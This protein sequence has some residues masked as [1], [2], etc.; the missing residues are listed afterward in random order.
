MTTAYTSILKLALPVQGELVGTWGDVVNNNITSMIEEAIAGKA[1]ISTWVVGVHTLTTANGTTS[2]SRCAILE[3]SGSPGITSY[4]ICPAATKLYI[5]KNSV[6]GGYTVTLKTA[7]GS[8][9]TVP[10]G[11][12]ML[13]YCDGTNVVAGVDYVSA[14]Y[15]AYTSTNLSGGG[16]GQVPYQS[17]SGTT[18]M[19]AAGSAGQVLTSNGT[20]APSWSNTAISATTATNLAGGGAGQVPYQSGAGA[21]SMLAAG[22]SGQVLT[23]NGASAPS[24]ASI[25]AQTYPGAGIAVSTGSAWTTSKTS[26]SGTIVGTTDTQTLTNKTMT[27]VK[28]TR[29]AMGA[30]DIDLS[31]GNVFT[32]TISGSTT[33]T[34]SNVPA[35]GTVASF[36][37]DVTNPG[38]NITWFSGVKWPGGI[39]PILSTS[40]R[41]V[42]GFFTH[43]GGT[44]WNGFL[45]GKGMA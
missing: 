6:S 38:T 13:L 1:S 39:A 19:L 23:S 11:S 40:G 15:S 29:V 37:F 44:T 24:W 2:E 17:G 22:T 41:D 35:A 43:D 10:N 9:I 14:A 34:V 28:E 5:V 31:A 27:G 45:L 3:C 7:S 36:I 33:L 20:S 32:K 4:V 42:L 8:G 21:T 12:T 30:S 26:P 18:A 25:P 16:A